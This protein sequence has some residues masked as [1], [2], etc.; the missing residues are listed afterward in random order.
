MNCCRSARAVLI[1][2]AI[3]WAAVVLATSFVLEGTGLMG[4]LIPI[5]GGGAVASIILVGR[6]SR[7]E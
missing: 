5:L 3:I 2:N 4:K 7:K 6:G 1:G